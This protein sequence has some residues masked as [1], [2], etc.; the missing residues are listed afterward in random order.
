MPR[1][2]PLYHAEAAK[3]LVRLRNDL[4]LTQRQVVEHAGIN[5]LTGK[6]RISQQ[7]LVKLEGGK[8]QKPSTQN[9]ELLAMVYGR[10]L[11]Q[12]LK[13]YDHAA[14]TEE[15]DTY[16]TVNMLEDRIRRSPADLTRTYLSRIETILSEWEKDIFRRS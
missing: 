7:Q 12:M 6:P 4:G 16:V 9:L 8:I 5:P 15:E 14:N 1:R 10:T 3:T 11:N 13:M 2:A